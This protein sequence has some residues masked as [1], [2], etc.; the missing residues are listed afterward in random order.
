V[1]VSDVDADACI[2]RRRGAASGIVACAEPTAPSACGGEAD[3]AVQLGMD[4][5]MGELWDDAGADE[6][7]VAPTHRMS[8]GLAALSL[9]DNAGNGAVDIK[10]G[11]V[12]QGINAAEPA[13]PAFK[14]MQSIWEV[15]AKQELTWKL[16]TGKRILIMQSMQTE[17]SVMPRTAIVPVGSLIL[18]WARTTVSAL[19]SSV[20]VLGSALCAH[21]LSLGP[22]AFHT[23]SPLVQ[24]AQDP[25]APEHR[26]WD[27]DRLA[28][29]QA[30]ERVSTRSATTRRAPRSRRQKCAAS[31]CVV[32]ACFHRCCT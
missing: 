32:R 25:L 22:S 9:K 24:P 4:V 1:R 31:P 19:Q 2:A 10:E 17:M 23:A 28:A 27:L 15:C 7:H 29:T 13:A 18:R 21:A 12:A 8:D 14:G 30:E 16:P 6:A 11:G 26:T 5:P 20:L 3:A